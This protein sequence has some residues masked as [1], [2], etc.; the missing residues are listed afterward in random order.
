MK[1]AIIGAGIGGLTAAIALVLKGHDVSVFE[2]APEL[3]AI[4][5]GVQISPNGHHV[6]RA[7]DVLPFIQDNIFHPKAIE[8]RFGKTGRKVFSLPI[9]DVAQKRWHAPYINIHRADLA[10]GLVQRLKALAPN[11][12]HLGHEFIHYENRSDGTV[13]AR[14]R[15]DHSYVFDVLIGADGVHS[16]VRTQMHGAEAPR[17]TGNIAWRALVPRAA[18]SSPPPPTA[19][20]WLGHKRHAVTTYIE[21]GDT[22]NF[23]GIVE[24][25]GWEQDGWNIKGDITEAKASFEG[26]HPSITEI[27]SQAQTL[28][29]WALLDRAPLP[30]WSQGQVVLLG[31]AAHPMLPSMAQG[32]VQSMEDAYVLAECLTAHH[33]NT[34]FQHYFS[35]RIDRV[36]KIQAGSSANSALFHRADTWQ[37]WPTYGPMMLAGAIIPN[38][39]HRRQDWVYGH[40][41]TAPQ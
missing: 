27:L 17:F 18:I 9:Q 12:L 30:F 8:M 14:F 39:I 15:N 34:A 36:S 21:G 1:I 6:L 28:H 19:C 41:V 32:A 35:K 24:Q 40:D 26:W 20:I 3:M 11:A 31:D 7:L 4:G 25:Q 23:V 33:P 16:P 29:K 38:A 2:R 13:E 22:I 5:A 10:A 37:Q